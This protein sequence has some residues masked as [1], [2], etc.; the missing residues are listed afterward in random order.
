[1]KAKS[2]SKIK[3]RKKKKE[4]RKKRKKETALALARASTALLSVA[5]PLGPEFSTA[6]QETSLPDDQNRDHDA[7]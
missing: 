7:C 1:M 3:K 2:P 6:Q 4:K 5:H